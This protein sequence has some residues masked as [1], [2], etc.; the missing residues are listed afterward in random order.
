MVLY[1]ITNAARWPVEV[2]RRHCGRWVFVGAAASLDVAR[3]RWG[4]K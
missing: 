2:Y 4:P 3:K 1:Q